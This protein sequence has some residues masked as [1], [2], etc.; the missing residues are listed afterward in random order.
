MQSSMAGHADCLELLIASG[1]NVEL[2]DEVREYHQAFAVVTVCTSPDLF[3]W[4]RLCRM[5][6]QP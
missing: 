3:G 2:K 1:A 5:A 6:A 4:L